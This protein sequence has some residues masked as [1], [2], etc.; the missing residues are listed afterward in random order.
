MEAHVET[1]KEQLAAEARA[2]AA[3]A[4]IERQAADFAGRD[5]ERLAELAAR[6]AALASDLA[7]ERARTDKAI[8]AFERLGRAARR[9][10]PGAPA[11]VAPDGRV[12]VAGFTTAS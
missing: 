7:A 11:V 8:A 1:L 3:E 12:S 4:R 9:P 5:A 2:N 10:G 6:E